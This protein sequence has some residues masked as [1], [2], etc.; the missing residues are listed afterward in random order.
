MRDGFLASMKDP[1]VISV[2]SE[3]GLVDA[4]IMDLVKDLAVAQYSNSWHSTLTD[5]LVR[6]RLELSGQE[7]DVENALLA[8]DDAE[9]ALAQRDADAQAWSSILDAIE[10][11]RKLVDTE[12]RLLEAHQASVD[13]NQMRAILLHV[14]TAMREHVM[15][16]SGGAKAVDK[17]ANE[18]RKLLLPPPDRA[19]AIPVDENGMVV[20]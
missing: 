19:R 2:R 1:N 6:L 8:I 10:T 14:L 13:V 3:L 20:Q 7:I 18:I 17:V 16:L 15:P 12:R 5:E 11:R 9:T 4:R